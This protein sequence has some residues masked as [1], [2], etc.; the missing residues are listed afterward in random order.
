MICKL[1]HSSITQV[2]REN[3][4]KVTPA[5]LGLL[6][7]FEHVKRP[8]SVDELQQKIGEG[9]DR[10]TLYRNVDSLAELGILKKIRL[11]ERKV[12]YETALGTHHH[13]IVCKDC[14]KVEDVMECEVKV[15]EKSILKSSG[16]SKITDH[17]LE[18]FGICNN[19]KK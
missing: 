12:Y 14:G 17:S 1:H 18:F 7:V 3:N 9:V 5:R 6:D 16:F 2:L 4:L 13:H 19:C 10:V 8:L 11:E 15:N